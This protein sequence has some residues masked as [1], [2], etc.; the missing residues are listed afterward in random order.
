M[1]LN[2]T[3]ITLLVERLQQVRIVVPGGESQLSSM[4]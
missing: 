4:A 1:Y 2:I 3:F